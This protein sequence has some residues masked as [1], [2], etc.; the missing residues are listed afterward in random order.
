MPRPLAHCAGLCRWACLAFLVTSGFVAAAQPPDPKDAAPSGAASEPSPPP[1]T[2]SEADARRVAGLQKAIETSWSAGKF[3]EALVPASQIVALCEKA[4]GPDH[5]LT[6]DAQRKVVTLETIAGLP[7]KGQRALAGVPALRLEFV[8]ASEKVRYAD[9]ER[10]GRRI[11]EVRRR[12]LGEGHPD[13]ADCYNGLGNIFI[14][15]G[16]LPEA[17]AMYRKALAI[18]LKALGE[19]HP[20]TAMAYYNLAAVPLDQGK[21][22]EAEAMFRKALAIRLKALGEGHLN[23]A[24]S[25]MGLALVLRGEGRL[26][27]AEAMLRRAL[28]IVC[29]AVGEGHPDTARAYYNLTAVLNDQGM[30]PEAEVMLRRALAAQ[31]RAVGEGHPVGP[32]GVGQ[33]QQPGVVQGVPLGQP[34]A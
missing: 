7:E 25:Y 16:K 29:K 23:S 24:A 15:Q 2:L 1:K 26:P 22:L 30:L 20:L 31:L 14:D 13:T 11:E 4:V 27:E 19:G 32:Q 6:A 18:Y 8:D 17:E 9:A 28:A 10:L 21:L 33:G 5:W 12:W 3:A 34:F